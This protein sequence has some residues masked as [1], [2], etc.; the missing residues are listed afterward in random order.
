MMRKIYLFILCCLPIIQVV[1][2]TKLTESRVTS[3]YTYI[4]PI[5]T[6]QTQQF[7]EGNKLFIND[8]KNP[9][10]SFKTDKG[11][12]NKTLTFG[13][14]L[15]I[16]ANKSGLN[17]KLRESHNAFINLFKDQEGISFYVYDLAGNPIKD[18]KVFIDNK[19]VKANKNSGIYR[20]SN[21]KKESVIRIDYKGIPNFYAAEKNGRNNN[22]NKLRWNYFFTDYWRYLKYRSPFR[23][24]YNKINYLLTSPNPG[25]IAL[26]KPIYKPGDTVKLKAF[27]FKKLNKKPIGLKSLT[28]K[29]SQTESI[30][31]S[32]IKPYRKGAYETSFV[33][34]DSLDLDLDR[35]TSINLD[36]NKSGLSGKKI[37]SSFKYEDYELKSVTFS[38]RTDK[39]KFSPKK[40]LAVY[41]KAVD[42]N[43][44]AVLDGRVILN[45]ITKNFYNVI[46]SSAFIPDTLYTKEIKLDAIG[47]TKFLITDSLLPKADLDFIIDAKFL[48]SNNEKQSTSKLVKFDLK[49]DQIQYELRS[50]SLFLDYK[51]GEKS[52]PIKAFINASNSDV[53]TIFNKQVDLPSFIIVSPSI[54]NYTITYQDKSEFI[55][56]NE[57]KDELSTSGFLTKDSLFINVK[58]VRKIPF[59]YTLY[60]GSNIIKQ[61]SGNSN[62]EIT[63]KYTSNKALIIIIN[64]LW[65]GQEKRQEQTFTFA[66][67]F[68]N[69]N[70]NQPLDVY[71]GKVSEITIKVTDFKGNA[72]KNADLTSY[73]VTSKIKSASLPNMPYFGKGHKIRKRKRD[74]QIDAIQSNGAI[75]LN[76][77]KW[78]KNLGL[79]SINYFRFTHPLDTLQFF[80][81]TKDG[82]TQIAPFVMDKGEI[83]PIHFLYIDEFPVYSSQSEKENRYSFKVDTGFHT[84][85]IRTVKDE[86][87]ISKVK[88]IK[89]YKL[90]LSVN[91]NQT[92]LSLAKKIAMPDTLTKT[93]AN[94]LGLYFFKVV[95]NFNNRLAYLKQGDNYFLLNKN[96]L[97]NYNNNYKREYLVGPLSGYTEFI[98]SDNSNQKDFLAD[99]GYS[100]EFNKSLIKQKS[101]ATKYAFSTKL[102]YIDFSSKYKDLPISKAEIEK[103]WEDYIDLKANSQDWFYNY[104]IKDKYTGKLVLQTFESDKQIIRNVI[105]S[106]NDNPDDIRILSGRTTQINN[107]SAGNYKVLFLF[108][109]DEFLVFN[110]IKIKSYGTNHYK[111]SLKNP[112]KNTVTENKIW[113]TIKESI[114]TN[115]AVNNYEKAEVQQSFNDKYLNT[116]SYTKS[117]KGKVIND[118][119]VALPGVAISVKGTKYGTQTDANG[120]FS[121]KAPNNGTLVFAF[122]GFVSTEEKITSDE[123]Y[124]IILVEDSKQLNEV[125]VVGYGA[126]MKRSLSA[127]VSSFSGELQGRVAGVNI[128]QIRGTNSISSVTAPLVIVDG[129]PYSGDLSSID[130][131]TIKDMDILKDASATAIYGSRAAGGVIIITT[132]K[133][134][135]AVQELEVL[136]SSSNLRK[137]FSDYAYWQP[138]LKTDN[139]GEAKFKVIF[140]DDITNWKTFVIGVGNKKMT[141]TAE[142]NIRSFKTLS[143]NI[144]LPQFVI[145]GDNFNLIGKILNYTP[146]ESKVQRLF[147]LNGEIVSKT[148]LSFKNSLI[149][150]FKV[151]VNTGLDTLKTEYSIVQENGYFD[152]EQRNIPVFKSGTIET[153]GSFKALNSDTTLTFTFD[154]K[155]GEVKFNAV[156][157]LIPVLQEECFNLRNYQYLCNEQ[158]ASKL[159][160]L[161]TERRIKTLQK[162]PFKD[163]KLIN[164]AIKKLTDNKNNNGI[165][166][167]WPNTKEEYWISN[168]V[169]N[170]L[171]KAE[172]DGFKTYLNKPAII[173]RLVFLISSK[174]TLDKITLL[175]TLKNLNA[176]VNYPQY[177]RTIESEISAKTSTYEKLRFLKLK[178]VC[179][180]NINIDSL[181]KTQKKTMLGNIYFGEVNTQFFDNAVQNSVL[182]YNILK[183]AKNYANEL[184]LLRNFFLEQRSTGYW[185]NTYESALILETILPDI[186]KDGKSEAPSLNLTGQLN[187]TITSFPFNT[188]LPSFSPLMIKRNGDLPVYITAFQQFWNKAPDKKSDDFEI[189]TFFKNKIQN[190]SALTAGEEVEL[191]VEVTPR[192]D[193]DYVMIEVP[194]PA[195][196]SYDSKDQSW[197]G[198]TEIHREY[199]KNKV[200]IFCNTLKP[201]KYTFSIKLLPRYNGDYV[202]NPAKAELMYFPTFYGREEM[203]KVVVD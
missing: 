172:E 131:N 169:L 71:P 104:S 93:E 44:L 101:L 119:K 179:K 115:S 11:L 98:L 57:F 69:L 54:E 39:E 191:I 17:Y 155:N 9:I 158:L 135:A 26:N 90:L 91:L 82:S 137:N 120:N 23:V 159:I 157:S 96:N 87:I 188:T 33:L 201:R 43:Q 95:D 4:Y 70:V 170:A 147:K 160:G 184:L 61:G 22:Y 171:L 68:L 51:I 5:N 31:I 89:G 105:I 140:P 161:L 138:T 58:N 52:I 165:W 15:E 49:Y 141:G 121:L 74:A 46:D 187:Q 152:G 56:M 168:H 139:N 14:Y 106:N 85:K 16:V 97:N 197:W 180:E 167:W 189:K 32:E 13:N 37:S 24:V 177:L 156:A 88:A 45:L 193:A 132:T 36:N 29:I 153:L 2:Q 182:V 30:K 195:G 75:N 123:N 83:I 183:Q 78:A 192:A 99:G 128:I 73:A 117:I 25:Y 60:S 200:S 203:K 107:L 134:K 198:G 72:V 34:H 86:L 50:D 20:K 53:D 151:R 80:E 129:L 175:E 186:L 125:V 143:A 102:K 130:K 146:V 126:Q 116:S 81:K 112:L 113:K 92:E 18:A 136:A 174:T 19:E 185:R 59:K 148:D 1:A 173:D 111:L 55:L 133:S 21:V 94:R 66:K 47:E 64:Y 196:C 3:F 142:G 28:L 8:L 166:G 149:D 79:D 84:L 202:L 110:D 181:L 41:F 63:D 27:L 127:S 150:T 190:V 42:E 114:I 154:P 76:W 6:K 65:A 176:E 163:D 109:N 77:D 35:F 178:Q 38:M 108:S 62:L 103:I 199:F 162:A 67:K 118:K 144:A 100:F 194:I 7:Y 12:Y 164:E 122:I 145:E 124:E 48:N 10:D 40:P